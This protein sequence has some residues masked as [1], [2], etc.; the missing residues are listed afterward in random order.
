MHTSKKPKQAWYK[1][2]LVKSLLLG[3]VGVVLLATIING[4]TYTMW[5]SSPEKALFDAVDYARKSPAV[6][7]ITTDTGSDYTVTTDGIQIELEGD[8]EGVDVSA[9]ADGKDLYV[10]SVERDKLFNLFMPNDILE[11]STDIE[12]YWFT[13]FDSIGNDRWVH[14]NDDDLSNK[15]LSSTALQCAIALRGS[16]SEADDSFAQLQN[17]Y[18]SNQFVNV[19]TSVKSSDKSTHTFSINDERLMTFF[20]KLFQTSV[21]QQAS[22]CGYVPGHLSDMKSNNVTFD[23]TI[24]NSDHHLMNLIVKQGNKEIARV[25]ANYADQKDIEIPADSRDIGKIFSSLL[26]VK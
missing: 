1:R 19:H 10:K 13:L 22:N 11:D 8:V 18:Q 26:R 5:Q 2:P 12:S 21:G 25:I 14:I 6:Y 24:T 15:T 20:S 23:A 17:A 16:I 9:V 3:L 7:T 4:L